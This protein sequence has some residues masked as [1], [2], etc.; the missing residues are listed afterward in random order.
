MNPKW[1]LVYNDFNPAQE[2][3]RESLCTLG[4]GYFATRGAAPESEADGIHYPGTYFAGVYNRLKSN[5]GGQEIENEDLVNMPNWLLL[6]FKFPDGE[7]FN[8]LNVDI[9]SYH[10]SLDIKQGILTRTIR[11]RDKQERETTISERRIVH[12]RN[13]HLA[14]LETT[15]TPENWSGIIQLHSALDGTVTNSGVERYKQLSNK[16]LEPVK[17]G[18]FDEEGIYLLV[19]TNQSHIRVAEAAKTKIF[20]DGKKKNVERMLVERD[21]YIAQDICFEVK[22]K[23]TVRIEKLI[24]FYTSNDQNISEPCL[25]AT[26]ALTN[27]EGFNKLLKSHISAWEHLWGRCDIEIEDNN[28]TQAILR[29]HIFHLLQTVSIHSIGLDTGVPAR[30]LHGEAYRGHVFWDELFIIPFLTVRMPEIVR[31]LFLYRYRRLNKARLIAKEQGLRGAL[32]PWQSGSNGLEESQ[33]LHLNPISRRWNQ[34]NTYLQRHVNVA[35][36]YNIWRYLETTNDIQFL[37][38]Y[39]AEIILE[40][41]RCL[42]SMTTYNQKLDRFEIFGVVGP[43]EYHDRYPWTDKP[44][45][46]NNAYTNV[47]TVWVLRTAIRVLNLL[48]PKRRKELQEIIG[49][50]DSEIRRWKEII[51]KIRVLFHDGDIISQFEGYEKLKEFDWEGYRKKYSNIQRLDRILEAEGDTTNNYKVSKQADVLMLLYIFSAEDLQELFAGM[52]YKFDPKTI[53]KNID[54]YLNR[55]SH[56]STL[57]NVVHSWVLSRSDRLASWKYFNKALESDISDIQGGTTKEGIHLSAMAGSVDIVQRCYTG[58]EFHND[59]IYFNP[60]IP[61]EIHKLKMKIKYRGTWFDIVVTPESL[62]LSCARQ[63]DGKV[64]T[65]FRSKIY[66]LEPSKILTFKI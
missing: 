8:L 25:A 35:I 28:H 31:A 55:T 59:I 20:L 2:G 54:Y 19:E 47:M 49:L 40:I 64:K 10:Q 27:S 48:H 65:C 42:A 21:G 12:M 3:L 29:L 45:I 17:T 38:A 62:V 34:D 32:Y 60:T 50:K 44:G 6:K 43:D 46:N 15:I 51:H 52:G 58:M 37:S 7:W 4:N 9:L 23:K 30:G 22:Q 63:K 36:V 14:A 39:G 24:S 26:K 1:T 16:H 57:S 33:K 41:T 5:I 18:M 66:E 11:F 13:M 53:P 61:E 56:G